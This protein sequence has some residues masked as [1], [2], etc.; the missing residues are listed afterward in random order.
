MIPRTRSGA[1][2]LFLRAGQIWH[3]ERAKDTLRKK[4]LLR[5]LGFPT[6]S[7][8]VTEMSVKGNPCGGGGGGGR[9]EGRVEVTE[10]GV[11]KRKYRGITQIG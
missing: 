10:Q 8:V 5:F 7:T 11:E 6:E 3:G 1:I 2:V 9:C 4:T